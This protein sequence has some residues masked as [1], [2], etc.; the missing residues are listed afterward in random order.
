MIGELT[1]V[2]VLVTDMEKALHFYRDVLGLPVRAHS[3]M[4]SDAKLGAITLGI[5]AGATARET[6]PDEARGGVIP[7]FDVPS[8]TE[9]QARLARH[10]QDLTWREEPFGKIAVISD[11]DGNQW[12]FIERRPRRIEENGAWADASDASDVLQA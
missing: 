9:L 7:G 12:Q 10:G 6:A 2:M 1:M 5:H 8:M 4:W 3:P 11:P